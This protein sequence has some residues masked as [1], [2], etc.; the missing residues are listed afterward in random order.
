M[1]LKCL[2]FS[3]NLVH[4][5]SVSMFSNVKYRFYIVSSFL[6]VSCFFS[7]IHNNIANWLDISVHMIPWY[8]VS[9]VLD[10]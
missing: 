4:A 10:R 9:P 2:F 3:E 1:C 8:I 6:Y 5:V 7:P